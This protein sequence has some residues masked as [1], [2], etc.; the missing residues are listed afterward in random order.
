MPAKKKFPI[1]PI[2]LIILPLWLIASGAFALVKYFKDE[3]ATELASQKRFAQSVS[4]S[5]IEDN[6]KKIITFI[7]ERNTSE[8]ERLSA[9]SSMIQGLLGQSNIGFEVF[10][11]KGPAD[12]PLIQVTIPSA[13]EDAAPVWLITSYDSPLGS[14]GAEKNATG[15]VATIATAQALAADQP[16]H[17]IRFLFIPHANEAESPLVETA[18]IV[19]DLINSRPT[20]KAILCVE[21]MSAAE[22]LILSSRDTEV[23]PTTEFNGLGEILGAEITCLGDDFDL[24]STLFEMNLPALRVATRPTLLPEEKDEKLPFAPTLA[25]STGRLIEL[26]QRL[27]K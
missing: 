23:Y 26:V 11:T 8:P 18:T 9:T 6:L 5:D 14:T 24:A 19:K 2:L 27:S 3:K 17:P 13:N 21:A 4:I 1:V 16:A 10:T 12:F 20:A 15:I 22:P 7:G 25:A